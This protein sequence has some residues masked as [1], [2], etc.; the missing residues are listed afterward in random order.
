MA[1]FFTDFSEYTANAQPSDWTEQWNTADGAALVR[2]SGIPTGI[3]ATSALEVVNSSASFSTYAISWDEPGTPTNDVE[4]L[5]LCYFEHT[6]DVASVLNTIVQGGGAAGSEDGYIGFLSFTSANESRLGEYTAGSFSTKDFTDLGLTRNQWI[7]IRVR[8]TSS[9]DFDVKI[10]ADGTTEPSSW[11]FEQADSSLSSGWVG[12]GAFRPGGKHW[13]A[14]FG[15]GTNGDTAP[16]SPPEPTSDQQSSYLNAIEGLSDQQPSYLSGFEISIDQQE[17]Y[18][19]VGDTVTDSQGV[20]LTAAEILVDQQ[21]AY[22]NSVVGATDT[23]SAYLTAAAPGQVGVIYRRVDANN[24]WAAYVDRQNLQLR[25]DKIVASVVTNVAAVNLTSTEL[26]DGEIRVIAQGNRH[27]VWWKFK[28]RIDEEDSDLN[29]GTGVGL[30]S[31]DAA[32][33]SPIDFDDFYGQIH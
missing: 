28:L 11:T 26:T 12:F 29:N 1:K 31:E 19:L 30:Y 21:L 17:A 27:R 8:R 5:A 15:V 10:W 9:F 7:W 13:L 25:L 20:Y 24:Y 16:S 33:T 32:T 3:G 14:R 4:V 22:L 6:A 2:T 18:L 23:T